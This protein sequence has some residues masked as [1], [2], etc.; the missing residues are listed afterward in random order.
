M[1]IILPVGTGVSVGSGLTTYSGLVTSAGLWLNRTDLSTLI[2]DFI[3]M[4]EERL[5]RIL[6]VPDLHG[7]GADRP[8][9]RLPQGP[10]PL[11]RHRPEAGA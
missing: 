9:D 1:A 4:V 8:S 11:S 5:N 10:V 6:R 7:R 2:P 3:V